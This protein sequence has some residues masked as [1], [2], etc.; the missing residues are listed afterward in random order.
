MPSH[1]LLAKHLL[2]HLATLCVPEHP[3]RY[4]VTILSRHLPDGPDLFSLNTVLH[5]AA[6]SPRPRVTL[7]HRAPALEPEQRTSVAP[8]PRIRRYR[9]AHPSLSLLP[10]CASVATPALALT[11]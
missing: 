6:S 5:I 2:F 11:P 8:S 3:L 1:P 10:P 9:P 4:G 7:K